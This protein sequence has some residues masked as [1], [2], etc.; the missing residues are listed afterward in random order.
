[1][2]GHNLIAPPLTLLESPL[3]RCADVR[4]G[5][6]RLDLVHPRISG[7]KWFKLNALRQRLEAGE[8]PR[9]LSFG[10]AWS[11]HL[12]ALAWLGR[13]YGVETIGVVRGFAEQRPT[14]MMEDLRR[15]GMRL[16]FLPPARYAA[17]QAPEEIAR[18]RAQ[19]GPFELIPEGGSSVDAV[20]GCRRIWSLL[21]GSEWAAPDWLLT[22]VG[23]G[24]T[25][26]GLIAGRPPA[27][28]L[29]GVPVLRADQRMADGVRA[30]LAQ[31]GV[32]DP[33]GWQLLL[34]QDAGGYARLPDE[35][36]ALLQR[37][38][39]VHGVPLDPVY[40]LKVMAALHRLLAQGRFNAGSRILLLHTGGLQG[41]R[42]MV[43]RIA[44]RA[45]AFCGPLLV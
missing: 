34:G 13:H 44:R 33:G 23:T 14:A 25:L 11:N 15:W 5:I 3:Y 29:L 21:E 12:H 19:Y 27:C 18:L 43:E 24:G 4:V 22:A 28:R 8:R 7:N 30:L 16:T 41:R 37:F 42:G 6:L 26:A 31:A 35:L 38:E 9:I 45:P 10:G 40:T 36:A 1:M 20:A 39:A 2:A 32:A 17:K